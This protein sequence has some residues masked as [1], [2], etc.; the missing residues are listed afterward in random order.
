V[1]ALRGALAALASADVGLGLVT[2]SVE[3][4]EHNPR[5]SRCYDLVATH[6][7]A[8]VRDVGTKIEH[9]GSTSVASLAA[10]PILDI[11]IGAPQPIDTSSYIAQLEPAGF[12]FQTDLGTYGGLLF[13]ARTELDQVVAHIHVVDIDDFQWRRYLAFR[14]VLRS[15][16]DLRAEYQTLK[17]QSATKY[18][19]DRERYTQAKFNWILHTVQSIDQATS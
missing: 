18:P 3:L 11:A 7:R 16:P 6:L 10:K 12:K 19:S 13:H 14:D 2:G 1:S 8:A 17:Q 15:D 9:I 5:W 4:H